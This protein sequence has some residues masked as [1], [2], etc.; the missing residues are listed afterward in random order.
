MFRLQAP[1]KLELVIAW[2]YAAHLQDFSEGLNKNVLV[3]IIR[4]VVILV[5]ET[6]LI[7]TIIIGEASN[8]T[9]SR[10]NSNSNL[11]AENLACLASRG[12]V[13]A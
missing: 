11:F 9:S 12:L 8:S 2:G 10:E 13:A 1:G 4:I 5:V 3:V 6:I 7:V